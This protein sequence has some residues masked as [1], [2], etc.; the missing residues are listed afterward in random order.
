MHE[1]EI[2]C[3]FSAAFSGDSVER[4]FCHRGEDFWVGVRFKFFCSH[5][6]S[7]YFRKTTCCSTTGNRGGQCRALLIK[8]CEM[9]PKSSV[10]S[11][12]CSQESKNIP[13]NQLLSRGRAAKVTWKPSGVAAWKPLWAFDGPWSPPSHPSSFVPCCFLSQQ[14]FWGYC[15]QDALAVFHLTTVMISPR[16]KSSFKAP[17][18]WVNSYICFSLTHRGTKTNTGDLFCRNQPSRWM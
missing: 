9:Q 16:L 15:V 6:H 14:D 13:P 1:N 3:G 17:Y 11:G 18:L 12:L 2:K 10:T 7:A 8:I 4:R 5:L